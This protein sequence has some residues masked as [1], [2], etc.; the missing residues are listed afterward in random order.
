MPP[1]SR[2]PKELYNIV[3]APSVTAAVAEAHS[4][5]PRFHDV[6]DGL[7]WRL[8]RDPVPEEANEIVPG[9]FVIKSASWSYPGYCVIT[10]IYTVT[11]DELSIEEMRVEPVHVEEGKA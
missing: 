7:T 8:A 11:D 10:L 3:E 6:Y 1:P 5:Y 4:T 9:T 2:A